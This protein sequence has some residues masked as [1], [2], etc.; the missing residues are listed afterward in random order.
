MTEDEMVGW[1]RWLDGHGFEWTPG[2]WWTGRPGMLR[3]MELQR[4]GHDWVTELNWIEC[5][6]PCYSL[7]M[8]PSILAWRMDRGAW[9][10]I[11][12]GVAKVGHNWAINTITMPET[13]IIFQTSY[14]SIK[15]YRI[16]KLKMIKNISFR[17]TE[18]YVQTTQKQ[19]VVFC[20]KYTLSEESMFQ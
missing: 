3:F 19:A 2:W 11:V 13:N 5:K 17:P 4:V 7:H 1:H 15:K 9:L 20:L 6:F 8:S 10:A 16:S 12:P 14:T 18:F